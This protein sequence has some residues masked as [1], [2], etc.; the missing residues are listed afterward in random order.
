MAPEIIAGDKY[1]GY[2][3]DIFSCGV[4]LFNMMTGAGPFKYCAHKNDP[5]YKYAVN[6]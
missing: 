4:V 2:K 1:N 3:T 6:N 5:L